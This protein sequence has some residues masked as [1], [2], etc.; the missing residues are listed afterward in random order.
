MKTLS[1][2]T[3]INTWSLCSLGSLFGTHRFWSIQYCFATILLIL[4]FSSK[5]NAQSVPFTG[6]MIEEADQHLCHSG[7]PNPI[8]FSIPVSPSVGITY[9]WYYKNGIVSAPALESSIVGWTMISGATGSSYDPPAGLTSSRTYACYISFSIWG[10]WA[11]NVRYITVLPQL[12]SGIV[13]SGDQTFS[14]SGNP[15]PIALSSPAYGSSGDFQYRWYSYPGITNAPTGSSIPAGWTAV[16]GATN[17]T[18]DPPVQCKSITYALLVDPIGSPDCSP[19]WAGGQRKITINFSPGTIASGNQSVGE[20]GDPNLISFSTAATSGATFQWYYKSGL[21][22][23][24]ASTASTSG[25]T[26][27]SGATASSYN[28]P[29][30][31]QSSRTYACRVSNCA[32]SLWASGVRQI[33][34][35]QTEVNI[36][37]NEVIFSMS[38]DPQA[39]TAPT[40]YYAYQWYVYSGLTTAPSAYAGIPTGWV[41]VSGATSSTINPSITT[42]SKTYALRVSFQPGCTKW[43]SGT[44]RIVIANFSYGALGGTKFN[45]ICYGEDPAAFTFS[46]PPSTGVTVSWYRT[47]SEKLPTSPL[48]NIDTLV[49]A[50]MTYDAPAFGANYDIMWMGFFQKNYCARVS[51]GTSTY[52]LEPRIIKMRTQFINGAIHNPYTPFYYTCASNLPNTLVGFDVPRGASTESYILQWYVSTIPNTNYLNEFCAGCDTLEG[53]NW[54]A[55]GNPILRDF[56]LDGALESDI[57]LPTQIP[58]LNGP[59]YQSEAGNYRLITYKLYVTPVDPYS[60]SLEP[61]CPDLLES[62]CQPVTGASQSGG[63]FMIGCFKV[64]VLEC[65]NTSRY[66]HNEPSQP[67]LTKQGTEVFM[68]AYPNPA[69]NEFDLEYII[70]QNINLAKFVLINSAG[71]VVESIPAK[72]GIEKSSIHVQVNHLASGLYT[73]ALIAYG[74]TIDYHK[75]AVVN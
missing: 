8:V 20:C 58:A 22:S 26:I 11:S 5:H 38:G 57:A 52:W 74:K 1:N 18:Y 51:N 9:Q 44:Y 37:N 59:V 48:T 75:I 70:P 50:G 7:D 45:E 66:A 54:Q 29:A 47:M 41:A 43:A 32:V 34:V 14:L 25:W 3:Q 24:P 39:I 69:K 55:I 23:A 10:R 36:G 31:L 73:I 35:N 49:G 17:S 60:G 19:K 28:P 13:A 46:T 40:G 21:V 12:Y 63:A 68:Q 56:P 6:G 27:I 71:Q 72:T 15:S 67:L 64:G 61:L 62:Y 30:G 16:T 4:L 42:S 2:R 33:N 53:V 65:G